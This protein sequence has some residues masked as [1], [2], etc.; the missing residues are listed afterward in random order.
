MGP[1]DSLLCAQIAAMHYENSNRVFFCYFCY[2]LTSQM[3]MCV[4]TSI[5]KCLREF[6]Q[7]EHKIR[8]IRDQNRGYNNVVKATIWIEPVSFGFSSSWALYIKTLTK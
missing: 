8:E 4:D 5:I 2:F 7:A 3:L 1:I 6:N